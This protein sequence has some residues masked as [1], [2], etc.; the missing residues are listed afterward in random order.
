MTSPN[1]DSP[2]IHRQSAPLPVPATWLPAGTDPASARIAGADEVGRGAGA[3]PFLAASAEIPAGTQVPA[4]LADSKS[5]D[6]RGRRIAALAA[7]AE[8]HCLIT[9]VWY[10]VEEIDA[11]GIQAANIEAFEKIILTNGAD[12]TLVDGNLRLRPERLGA[13][14]GAYRCETRAERFAAVAAASVWAKVTRDRVMAAL[15]A[16]Y[17]GYGLE[18]A[19]Y[20]TRAAIEAIRTRGRIKGVHRFSYRIAALGEK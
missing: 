5:F 7:W 14:A 13:R 8:E 20:L 12:F 3:G 11:I 6:P 18:S 1:Y 9:P 10:A 16:Q 2:A 15:A 17:P 19:G 4:D